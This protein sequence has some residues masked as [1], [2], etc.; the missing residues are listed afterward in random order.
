M[1]EKQH[2]RIPEYDCRS[3]QLADDRRAGGSYG[4][5]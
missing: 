1:K 2:E 3:D 4:R 5:I